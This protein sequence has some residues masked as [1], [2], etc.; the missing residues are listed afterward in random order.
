M[1]PSE[2]VL[3]EW[4][5]HK[6]RSLRAKNGALSRRIDD[7]GRTVED[8]GV[9]ITPESIPSSGTVIAAWIS[10]GVS[11]R[12]AFQKIAALFPGD[13]LVI[14]PGA[15]RLTLRREESR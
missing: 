9:D 1:T 5:Q 7:L 3:P 10:P 15:E 2:R 8:R 14:L 6:L 13:R 11:S 12:P 4:A